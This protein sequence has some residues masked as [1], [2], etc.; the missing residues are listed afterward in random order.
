MQIAY[1]FVN[2]NVIC[3][4]PISIFADKTSLI[5]N[6]IDAS[7]VHDKEIIKLKLYLHKYELF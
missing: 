5:I 1:L 3:H 2:K 6:T 4:I 7:T